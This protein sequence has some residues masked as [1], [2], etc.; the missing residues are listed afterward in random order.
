MFKINF[1]KTIYERILFTYSKFTRTA[2]VFQN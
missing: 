1:V 2:A